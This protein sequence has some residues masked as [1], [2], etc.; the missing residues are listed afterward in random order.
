MPNATQIPRW[1]HAVEQSDG[2]WRCTGRTERLGGQ[3]CTFR[4]EDMSEA[5]AH[6]NGAQYDW[7]H[8]KPVDMGDEVAT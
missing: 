8:A 1:V 4:S 7:R 5:I 2:V 6:A 3:L